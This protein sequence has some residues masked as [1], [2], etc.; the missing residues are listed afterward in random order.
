MTAAVAGG[1]RTATPPAMTTA[2]AALVTDRNRP[3]LADLESTRRS[4]GGV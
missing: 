3:D 4:F 1:A 2:A